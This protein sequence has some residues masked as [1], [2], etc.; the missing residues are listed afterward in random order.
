M[1]ILIYKFLINKKIVTKLKGESMSIFP[2]KGTP[3]G[4]VLSPI[5]WNLVVDNWVSKLNKSNIFH[6][7]GVIMFT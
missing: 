7:K 6:N 2:G 5:I 1:G 3:Q 4:G